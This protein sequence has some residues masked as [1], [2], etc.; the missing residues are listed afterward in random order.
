MRPALINVTPTVPLERKA[1]DRA[2]EFCRTPRL[3]EQTSLFAHEDRAKV[4]RHFAVSFTGDKPWQSVCGVTLASANRI[5]YTIHIY[6][7]DLPVTCGRC[8]RTKLYNEAALGM[9][10]GT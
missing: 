6:N 3:P 10:L 5:L 8:K 4:T 7:Q 9:S 1:W 2:A